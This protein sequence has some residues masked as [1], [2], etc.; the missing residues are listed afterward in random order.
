ML[1]EALSYPFRGGEET[2][3]VGVILAVS[4]GVLVRLGVLAA[5]AVAPVVLLAGYALAVLRTSAE[6]E[7]APPEFS[8]FRALADD[9]LRAVV[10]SIVYLLVPGVVLAVTVGGAGPGGGSPSFGATVFVYAAGTVVLFVSLSFAY[11]LPAALAELARR[12]RL[13]AAFDPG[14]LRRIASDGGYFV[15]WVSALAVAAIAGA[16]AD[17]LAAF[18]RAGELAALAVAVYALLVVARVIGRSA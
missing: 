11:L 17:A 13:R 1:R 7:D 2:L 3:L 12:G 10:V 9:G 5:V 16:L 14:P 4:V 8:D 6:G 18:G 15:G